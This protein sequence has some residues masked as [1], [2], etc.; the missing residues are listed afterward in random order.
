MT[1]NLTADTNTRDN[2][3]SLRDAINEP[4]HDG[5]VKI[6]HRMV[7][8]HYVRTA[9]RLGCDAVRVVEFEGGG[10][11][12]LDQ[13]TTLVLVPA[14]ASAV[15]GTSGAADGFAGGRGLMAALALGADAVLLGTRFAATQECRG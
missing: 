3:L 6:M 15:A 5:E 13:V 9:E 11:P 1:V 4:L 8:F 2:K 7:G 14:T 10:H 12:G